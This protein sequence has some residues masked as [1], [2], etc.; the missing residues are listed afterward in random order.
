MPTFGRNGV[1]PA[2]IFWH[3]G[4]ND[5]TV[6][7]VEMCNSGVRAKEV[8]L[9]TFTNKACEE[10]LERV[11]AALGEDAERP[12]VKT[13]HAL[14]NFWVGQYWRRLGFAKRPSPLTSDA[15]QRK[16]MLRV[17]YETV[18]EPKRLQRAAG[19]LCVE[20]AWSEVLAR[21]TVGRFPRAWGRTGISTKSGNS[22]AVSGTSWLRR[23]SVRK[24]YQI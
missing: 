2:L 12:K 4:F 10:L 5:P 18:V 6:A 3:F 20:A 1:R 19:A 16:L 17:L 7:Q 15:A 21:A 9:V 11:S 23:V 8:L 14:A 24:L 13:F 22:E